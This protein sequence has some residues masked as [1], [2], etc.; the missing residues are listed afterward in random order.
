M[1]GDRGGMGVPRVY[2]HHNRY[3]AIVLAAF[4]VA[5]GQPPILLQAIDQAFDTIPFLIPL[6]IKGPPPPFVR[7]A[8]NGDPDA[9]PPPGR[10]IGP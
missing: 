10:R 6:T 3:S 7:F 1:G 4:F 5:G 8:G 9:A 2:W